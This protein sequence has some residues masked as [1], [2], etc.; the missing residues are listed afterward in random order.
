MTV[1]VVLCGDRNILWGMAVAARSALENSSAPLNLNVIAADFT[2]TDRDM[3][4]RSWAHENCATVRFTEIDI[5]KLSGFRSTAYLKS[6]LSYARYF[7]AD[8]FPHIDRC[9]YIDTDVIVKK[10]LAVVADMD[11]RGHGLAAALDVGTLIN[12]E[13]EERRRRL[14]LRSERNYFNAGV[15]IIDQPYWI[16]HGISKALVDLSI[17]KYHDLHSQDQDALNII[18]EDRVLILDPSW[19]TSQY[20]QPDPLDDKIIHLLG[21][22]KPWHALYRKK[23]SEPYYEQV[24][25]RT[26]YDYLDRTA[27]AGQ[28]PRNMMGLAALIEMVRKK[29]PTRDML[30]GKF[31]RSFRS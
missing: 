4:R 2:E 10:D 13:N 14:G 28:R 17:E 12:P 6:K 25:Y 8:L 24:I 23:F 19:N 30:V 26:F 31:K 29:T 27:Y 3:L 21:T 5:R 20:F 15:L 9:I 7:L 11:L 22:D 1:D 16:S 18:F